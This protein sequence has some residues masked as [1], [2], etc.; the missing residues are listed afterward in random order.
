MILCVDYK[1]LVA[2]E[3]SEV[4]VQVLAS[5]LGKPWCSIKIRVV[6]VL[7]SAGNMWS[8]WVKLSVVNI[9]SDTIL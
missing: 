4:V 3:L 1:E 5:I 6:E 7:W 2:V 9:E 8:R